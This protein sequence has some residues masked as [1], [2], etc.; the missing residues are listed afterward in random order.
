M[1]DDVLALQAFH[2]AVL[3][4]PLLYCIRRLMSTLSQTAAEKVIRECARNS[5]FVNI[6]FKQSKFVAQKTLHSALYESP[7]LFPRRKFVSLRHHLV[8]EPGRHLLYDF[9]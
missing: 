1:D 5:L 9:F 3:F 8:R 6:I 2:L 7:H 4:C